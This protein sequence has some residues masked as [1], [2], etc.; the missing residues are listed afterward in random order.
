MTTIFDIGIRVLF[1]TGMVGL[2]LW[3]FKR[4]INHKFDKAF[5]KYNVENQRAEENNLSKWKL[6]REACLDALSVVDG[7]FSN[8]DWE[9][10]KSKDSD[11]QEFS[12]T[13]ARECYN[14]LAIT[15][16]SEKVLEAYKNCL[17]GKVTPDLIVDL[18]NAVREELGYGKEF[19]K[20]DRD[21]AWIAKLK[22]SVESH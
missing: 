14:K 8:T 3:L 16:E 15:C 20:S 7:S 18:R 4:Y 10:H 5:E 2:I 13:K 11:K 6:K 9:N 21:N 12:T 17:L 22:G 1:G 19:D